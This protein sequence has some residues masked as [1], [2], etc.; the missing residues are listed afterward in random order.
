[1]VKEPLS[2]S[3]SMYNTD[4]AKQNPKAAQDFYIAMLRGARDYCNAYHGGAWRPD[5]IKLL[6]ANGVAPNAELLDSIPWPARNADGRP[7]KEFLLDVQRWY[8]KQG[9]VRSEFTLDQ[10]WE[11][12]F[13]DEANARLGPFKLENTTSTKAGCGKPAAAG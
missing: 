13:A 5:L 8:V 9:L 3:V 4:W 10:I 1:V 7:G 2:I 6:V 12:R 11:Q